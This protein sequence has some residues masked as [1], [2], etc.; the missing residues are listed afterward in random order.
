MSTVRGRRGGSPADGRRGSVRAGG[1]VSH[2]RPV[3]TGVHA[4]AAR[5]PGSRSSVRRPRPAGGS[6]ARRNPLFTGRAFLLGTLILLLALTLAGPV[7]QYLAGRAELVRLAAEGSALD[8]R[9]E[10]LRAR[11]AEQADPAYTV[12][13]ARER[14]MY[15]LPGDRLVIVEDGEAEDGEDGPATGRTAARPEV[16]WYTGLLES[17]AVAD[18]DARRDRSAEPAG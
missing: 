18:G 13:E 7:R 6:G 14:L 8:Q 4:P 10:D 16:P 9:A 3:R 17:V 1:R 2:T 15:V 12:R 11:L 5:R